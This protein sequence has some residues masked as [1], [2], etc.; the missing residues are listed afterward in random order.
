M[1][2]T[3]RENIDLIHSFIHSLRENT[4]L[5]ISMEHPVLIVTA[6]TS[7]SVTI[8]T[9]FV[10]RGLVVSFESIFIAAKKEA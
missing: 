7:M 5:M 3:L 6:L 8:K 9:Y 2:E 4:N 10:I 1:Q